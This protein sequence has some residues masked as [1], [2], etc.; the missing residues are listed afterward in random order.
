MITRTCSWL[1]QSAAVEMLCCHQRSVEE[2]LDQ[3]GHSFH[4]APR[5][6]TEMLSHQLYKYKNLETGNK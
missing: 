1:I 6:T 2:F 3:T 5:Q 4:R